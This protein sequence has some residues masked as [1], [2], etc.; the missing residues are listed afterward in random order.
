MAKKKKK[1]FYE[2]TLL[3]QLLPDE[4]LS[5][6]NPLHFLLTSISYK[7]FFSTLFRTINEEPKMHNFDT[8]L[9]SFELKL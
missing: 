7:H 4:F 5:V 3:Q 1:L 8:H 6:A 2:Y 9:S